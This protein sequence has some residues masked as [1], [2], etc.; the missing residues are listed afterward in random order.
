[1]QAFELSADDKMNGPFPLKPGGCDIH[2]FQ[3]EI[4]NS[5][6]LFDLASVHLYNDLRPKEGSSVYEWCL[7]ALL[8]A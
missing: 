7:A 3:I 6:N 4:Q 5:R 8:F 2:D 1:M